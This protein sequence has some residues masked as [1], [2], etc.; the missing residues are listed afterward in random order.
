MTNEQGIIEMPMARIGAFIASAFLLPACHQHPVA[1]DS[2]DSVAT[3]NGTVREDEDVA[4]LQ[5]S[6][7]RGDISAMHT[8]AA[9]YFGL[10]DPAQG[11][12]WLKRAARLGDCR[13]ILLLQDPVFNAGI[14]ESEISHWNEEGRMRGCEGDQH[15]P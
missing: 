15:R 8:L 6:A 12:D 4:A 11:Q 13:A 10:D 5:Q 2:S 1:Y 14:P 3:L 7:E 9:H